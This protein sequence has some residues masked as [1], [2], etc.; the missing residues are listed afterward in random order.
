MNPAILPQMVK[1]G[2]IAIEAAD[3][4]KARKNAADA[5]NAGYR[6]HKR[7]VLGEERVRVEQNSLAWE[8]MMAATKPEH[9]ALK[10][11]K[12]AERNVQRRLDRAVAAVRRK[13][14]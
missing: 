2:F 14:A 1:I 9:A 10:R 6:Q 12:A 4:K 13:K 8:A 11:A 5:L 3:A 7:N